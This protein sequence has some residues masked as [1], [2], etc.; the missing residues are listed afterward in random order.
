[1]IHIRVVDSPSIF[2]TRLF[3]TPRLKILLRKENLF[4][5]FYHLYTEEKLAYFSMVPLSR[6]VTK[7]ALVY[8]PKC[9]GRGGE[10][11]GL[12]Q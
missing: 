1:M 8:E 3:W 5:I 9:G 6:G 12:S 7:S 10:L 11:R 4:L 2:K